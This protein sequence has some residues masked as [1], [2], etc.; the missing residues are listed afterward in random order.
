MS[1]QAPIF[2]FFHFLGIALGDYAQ[3]IW[4]NPSLPTDLLA[5]NAETGKLRWKWVGPTHRRYMCAGDDEGFITRAQSGERGACCPNTWSAPTIGPDG[6]IYVGNQDGKFYAVRDANGDN[7]IDDVTEVS[8]YDTGAAFSSP[9]AA[10]AP[11]MVVMTACD[12]VYVFKQ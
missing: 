4:Q 8:A 1:I 6:T 11:G 9:G 7:V 3:K 10:F 2:N 12:G 5:F